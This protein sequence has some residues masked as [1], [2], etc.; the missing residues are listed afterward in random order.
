MLAV[1][2]E[3]LPV[4]AAVWKVKGRFLGGL[5]QPLAARVQ[6]TSRVDFVQAFLPAQSVHR[7]LSI[8]PY[9]AAF[10]TLPTRETGVG[11]TLSICFP[12]Y[13]LLPKS[14]AQQDRKPETQNCVPTSHNGAFQKGANEPHSVC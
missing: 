3:P 10:V 7:V 6:S 1:D 14:A 4:A 13:S 9:R 2:P 8:R 12:L 5:H 11:T